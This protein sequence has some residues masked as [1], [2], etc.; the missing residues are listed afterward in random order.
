MK[1]RILAMLLSALLVGNI[2]GCSYVTGNDIDMNTEKT[3]TTQDKVPDEGKNNLNAVPDEAVG[4][5]GTTE[6]NTAPAQEG[7]NTPEQEVQKKFPIICNGKYYNS[8]VR[9]SINEQN[10]LILYIESW[11]QSFIISN[12]EMHFSDKAVHAS[13]VILG[14][15]R[16][17]LIFNDSDTAASSIKIVRF[18]RGNPEVTAESL[19]YQ[20]NVD[21]AFHYCNFINEKI[22]Y[23]FFFDNEMKMSQLIKTT[24]AGK[25][26]IEQSTETVPSVDQQANIICAK[27][28]NEN[29]GMIS[30]AQDHD[31]CISNRTFITLDGGKTWEKLILPISAPFVSDL[32]SDENETNLLFALSAYDLLYENGKYTLLFQLADSTGLEK[33]WIQYFTANFKTWSTLPDCDTIDDSIAVLTEKQKAIKLYQEALYILIM[34][35]SPNEFIDWDLSK[36]DRLSFAIL[37]MDGN[38]FPDLVVN[39]YGDHA[40]LFYVSGQ[41]YLSGGNCGLHFMYHIKKDGTFDWSYSLAEYGAA[42]FVLDEN[43]QKTVK[44]FTVKNDG[45]DN[46]EL[47]IGDQ[48]V[49]KEEFDT[50]IAQLCNEPADFYDLTE[51]NIEK[52]VTLEIFNQE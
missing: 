16:G 23:L 39:Y 52:Y 8:E 27:M 13:S 38:E 2:G 29:V 25:T 6:E 3:E 47:F 12:Q 50:F 36:D 7:L 10:E 33:P 4:T 22:G 24:D 28:I 42:K 14:E 32:R 18:T 46:L 49:T 30:A 44:L 45:T 35:G 1:K 43:G 48:K 15:A 41:E 40:A 9:Y 17:A 21:Y 20:T 37:D 31:V 26:W 5:F 51:E 19:T 34:R 11:N